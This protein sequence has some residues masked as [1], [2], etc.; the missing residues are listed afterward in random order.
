MSEYDP[1][2]SSSEEASDDLQQVRELFDA[3]SRRYLRTPFSWA[4]WAV[5]LPL[6][7]LLTRPVLSAFG[8][9][10][11]LLL[12][13][14]AILLGG[15]GELPAFR[16][17]AAGGPASSLASWAFRTQTNLSIAAMALSVALAWS[18]ALGLLASLWLLLLGHSF[19][20]LGGLGFRPFRNYGLLH[21]AGGLAALWPGWDALVILALTTALANAW[22][23][24]Q[25]AAA[26]RADASSLES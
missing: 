24:L 16:R 2:F 23:A 14:F 22:M 15:V 17:G 3:A 26:R 9:Q 6:T 18:G 12:W 11:G 25:V 13:S 7:S 10:G 19:Y 5:V 8:P 4:I 20:A 1:L 21:Q